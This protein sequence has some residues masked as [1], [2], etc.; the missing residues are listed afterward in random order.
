MKNKLLSF[1]LAGI[2]ATLMSFSFIQKSSE[3]QEPEKSRHI[4]MTKIVNGKKVELD[5]VLH[6][7]DVFVWQG[8]TVGGKRMMKHIAKSDINK[9]KHV[10]VVVNREGDDENV[11]IFH[12]KD[13]KD[14][15]PMIWKSDSDEDFDIFTDELGD[16]IRKKIV[17][18]K[19][20]GDLDMDHMMFMHGPGHVAAPPVPHIKL[21]HQKDGRMIDLNDKNIIS[22]RKK[23]MSGNRE[24]I[25]IIRKKPNDAEHS[26]S[27]S[28][29][30]N[31]MLM[32]PPPPMPPHAPEV[33]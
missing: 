28:F 30:S 33:V 24:K 22:Y 2:T 6:N 11:M 20:L 8:D 19:R 14:G 26:S 25:E 7:Y 1:G 16:S 12:S 17:I 23:D 18:H 9:R 10:K 13:G 15:E 5:T 3:H 21:M 29:E 32:P 4:K 31:D 27:F